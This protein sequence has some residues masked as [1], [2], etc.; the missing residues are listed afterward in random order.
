MA[1]AFTTFSVLFEVVSAYGNVG[2]SL[3]Y[4]TINASM[5]GEFKTLSKLI[6]IAMQVRGKHRGLPYQLDRAVSSSIPLS[7]LLMRV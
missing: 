6:I 5:S 7:H 1:Q 3:G 4:P 2:L